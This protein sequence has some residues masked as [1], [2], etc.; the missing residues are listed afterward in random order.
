MLIDYLKPDFEFTDERGSLTQLVREG[1]SQINVVS[2]K[3][4][5]VR[6]G[7][8]HVLNTE[9]FYVVSGT[10]AL[11]V[12]LD[13]VREHYEMKQGDFFRVPPMTVHSFSYYEDT[14]LIGMYDRGVELENGKKDIVPSGA[15][16]DLICSNTL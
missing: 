14:V 6:G 7:H 16:A 8:Y 11:D 3:A 2:S 5:V 1:Y 13:G 4:G 10:F 9:V 12:F 15:L